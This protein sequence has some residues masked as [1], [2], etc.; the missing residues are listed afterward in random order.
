MADLKQ[1]HEKLRRYLQE[2]HITQGFLASKVF[3]S[4]SEFSR[5]LNDQEP[6]T[7]NDVRSIVRALAELK[8]ITFRGEAQELLDLM[9]CEHFSQLEWARDPLNKLRPDPTLT[10]SPLRQTPPDTVTASM[11]RSRY[12]DIV[13]EQYGVVTLPTGRIN[14]L[15]LQTVF[16]PLKMRQD[17][18]AAE[19]LVYEERRALLDEPTRAEDDPRRAW[20]ERE[21]PRYHEQQSKQSPPV[22]AKNSEEAL[23]KSPDGRMI[24]LGSPGSGKTTVLKEL[25]GK[26]I[27]RARTSPTALIPIFISLPELAESAPNQTLQRYLPIMLGNVG[28][29]ESYADV[30]WQAVQQGRAFLCLDGL[31]EVASHQRGRM[32]DSINA[33]ASMKGNIW[34]IGSRFS[35]YRSGQLKRGR[36]TEWELQPLTAELRRELAV[37]LLPAIYQQV[38]RSPTFPKGMPSSFIKTLE[39]HPR[40]STWGKNPLLLSLAAIVFV[41]TGTLPASRAALYQEV[42]NAV[43]KTRLK[44]SLRRTTVRMVASSLA[45]AFYQQ[46]KRIFTREMLLRLL[47]EIRQRQAEN[48]STEG[49]ARDFIDSGLLEIVAEGTY[50]FWHQTY[51]EY[52]AAGELAQWFVSPDATTRKRAWDLAW[53]KRTY[54]RW[55][56][57]LRLLVGV[58]IHEHR[59]EGVQRALS[60]LHALVNQRSQLEGDIGDLG[61]TLALH[62]LSE[63]D[64]SRAR[65]KKAE[66]VQIEKA[67]AHTWIDALLEATEHEHE[68][69]RERLL[70]LAEHI[71]SFSPS[72]VSMVSQRV[73][74]TSRDKNARIR[75]T[76]LQISGKLGKYAPIDCMMDAFNDTHAEV[77]SAAAHAV[78]ELGEHT[79][80]KA[81]VKALKNRRAV[82]RQAATQAV[83][84]MKRSALLK[85]LVAGLDDED[86]S[87][88]IATVK[89]L[90]ELGEQ[91]S[92]DMLVE[93]LNDEV[94]LVRIAA[95]EALGKLGDHMPVDRL[96]A[97]LDDPENLV[98]ATVIETLGKRTPLEK[99]IA[100]IDIDPAYVPYSAAYSTAMEVL[101]QVVS[102]EYPQAEEQGS[103]VLLDEMPPISLRPFIPTIRAF[104]QA[105]PVEQIIDALYDTD[106]QQSLEAASLLG[107]LQEWEALGTFV[108]SL[109]GTHGYLRA[110][111]LQLLGRLGEQVP[112]SLFISA[113]TD[114]YAQAR[115]AAAQALEERGEGLPVEAVSAVAL[116]DDENR[117]VRAAAL[118]ILALVAEQVPVNEIL[119]ET[120]FKALRDDHR[121]IQQPTLMCLERIGKRVTREQLTVLFTHEDPVIRVNAIILFGKYAS[122]YQLAHALKHQNADT[123]V[124]AIRALRQHGN[125]VPSYLATNMLQDENPEVFYA[126]VDLLRMLGENEVIASLCDEDGFPVQPQAKA[127]GQSESVQEDARPWPDARQKKGNDLI[128]SL[129]TQLDDHEDRSKPDKNKTFEIE[130]HN[131]HA[132]AMR[133]HL[134]QDQLK[135]ALHD[136]ESAVRLGALQALEA[137]T[138]EPELLILLQDEDLHVRKVALQ[139][140]GERVPR[141]QLLIALGDPYEDVRET[142]LQVATKVGDRLPETVLRA[143]LEHNNRF[144]RVS[145]IRLLAERAPLEKLIAALGD[146]E[147]DVRFA[148]LDILCQ[149]YPEAIPPLIVD[150]TTVVTGEGPSKI[151]ASA[152]MSF[153]AEVIG[154]LEHTPKFLL[155]ELTKLLD[156]PYWEVRV[157]AAQALGKLR[158]N[159]PQE[160]ILRLL[161]LRNESEAQTVCRAADDA[162][163]EI[164]SLEASLEED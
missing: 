3:L 23:E 18:L 53:E 11:V 30:L 101:G 20:P 93:S 62:S 37:R 35:E 109:S 52:L 91:I 154:S 81:V 79:P 92:V 63:G 118:R 70:I 129:A 73:E 4:P 13:A 149:V 22:I 12:L 134:S 105:T 31:D 60:W 67:V 90:G 56:E 119:L 104:Q 164:L 117:S 96:I 51:Q 24:V 125:S 142:A 107:R 77:R 16:Q 29:D 40:A 58:L 75:E 27:Q 87:V 10:Q 2:R 132:E 121:S 82:V 71:G 123:R 44:D 33:L 143:T 108:I 25:V 8:V 99:A 14:N 111:A 21:E 47:A 88:R 100:E 54:S 114:I 144:M 57:V 17:S 38:H 95:V 19:D 48:W 65:W 158:R 80:V 145:A 163:A 98:R 139:I 126:A 68:A 41:A 6:L 133:E 50:G 148:A 131:I 112:P 83:G 102:D 97:M 128:F 59:D 140:L 89:A 1:F 32:I 7:P 55:I 130:M 36:F 76:A 43:L 147:K 141:E 69:R 86:W 110:L 74:R 137:Q 155:D 85:Y 122:I 64:E 94:S 9:E 157:K 161:T 46:N 150:L 136:E 159:I 113:L 45:L 61:L 106:K 66:W 72:V 138:P 146:S 151:V 42:I 15:S 127:T 153:L 162:L 34:I 124:A 5:R 49:V 84:A 26:A 115:L 28:I 78:A 39:R 116:L 120:L 156:W 160:A 135:V 152:A 103:Q